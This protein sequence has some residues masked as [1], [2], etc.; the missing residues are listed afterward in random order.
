MDINANV[1]TIKPMR[2]EEQFDWSTQNAEMKCGSSNYN[3]NDDEDTFVLTVSNTANR[4]EKKKWG[5]RVC[6][7]ASQDNPLW[8]IQ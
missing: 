7:D 2:E 6:A 5:G 4:E 8:G 3:N 1:P